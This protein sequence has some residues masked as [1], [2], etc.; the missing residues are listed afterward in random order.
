MFVYLERSGSPTRFFVGFVNADEIRIVQG[1]THDVESAYADLRQEFGDA[2]DL[3][4]IVSNLK[5]LGFVEQRNSMSHSMKSL[6]G[7]PYTEFHSNAIAEHL[8]HLVVAACEFSAFKNRSTQ[9]FPTVIGALEC[10][11]S[12]GE[13]F[14]KFTVV[15]DK[16]LMSRMQEPTT[17]EVRVS[18]ISA[19][20]RIVHRVFRN[21][22][23]MFS[24][25]PEFKDFVD[26]RLDSPEM[27]T[28][29]L[30]TIPT[31]SEVLSQLSD[32]KSPAEYWDL[33]SKLLSMTYV[34]LE[35]DSEFAKETYRKAT[36]KFLLKSQFASGIWILQKTLID[37]PQIP[38]HLHSF[39]ELAELSTR[40]IGRLIGSAI[41]DSM[42]IEPQVDNLAYLR[43]GAKGVTATPAKR[44]RRALELLKLTNLFLF[45][46][47]KDAENNLAEIVNHVIKF[48]NNQMLTVNFQKNY[49]YSPHVIK[50][51]AE[52]VG[53]Q[54]KFVTRG[55][56]ERFQEIEHLTVNQE[57]RSILDFLAE[58]M[59]RIRSYAEI[60]RTLVDSNVLS[61]AVQNFKDGELE[62]VINELDSNLEEHLKD[63]FW[64][65]LFSTKDEDLQF[66]L[67][68][69][70]RN[71]KTALFSR[72]LIRRVT[73]SP[74]LRSTVEMRSELTMALSKIATTGFSSFEIRN[75]SPDE[76]A[77]IDAFDLWVLSDNY[78][79]YKVFELI[80][81]RR[82]RYLAKG[83][84][85]DDNF[86]ASIRELFI[87][88]GHTHVRGLLMEYM[89]K[90]SLLGSKT[91][92]EFNDFTGVN[93]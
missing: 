4:E 77:V 64:L 66:R 20:I 50:T 81:D 47:P 79:Q 40:Y 24:I 90:A 63:K 85:P 86:N 84:K 2:E 78:N 51:V 11:S 39:R 61:R 13:V 35:T 92:F 6:V 44:L 74:A 54:F 67:I 89:A 60:Q 82:Y 26:G 5:K 33:G 71:V 28:N 42:R 53:N 18:D 56:Y 1:V 70:L 57:L 69:V 93:R 75:L 80:M 32:P 29:G 76:R 37:S 58:Q 52:N 25:F 43:P 3:I 16:A 59:A 7:R 45:E 72:D 91:G 49:R 23:Y 73:Y 12:F 68:L 15:D 38:T 8:P 30:L 62:T 9:Y 10:V 88:G 46:D 31:S 21:P 27:T 34:D 22:E 14:L 36:D 17:F 41:L 48:S 83:L 19:G 55:E 87:K 65:E